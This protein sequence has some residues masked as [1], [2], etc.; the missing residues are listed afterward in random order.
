MIENQEA[1]RVENNKYVY[2]NFDELK[3]FEFKNLTPT[4]NGN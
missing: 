4:F 3:M 2:S 1:Q